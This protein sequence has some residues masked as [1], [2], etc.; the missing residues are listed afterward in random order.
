MDEFISDLTDIRL[1][2]K[3]VNL[4]TALLF[5]LQQTSDKLASWKAPEN[6]AANMAPQVCLNFI[7]T[8]QIINLSVDREYIIGRDHRTQSIRPD[9]DLTPY[10]AYEWGISRLHAK[11]SIENGKVTI[12]DIGSSNGTWHA[13]ERLVPGQPLAVNNG[14]VIF[15]GKLKIQVLIYTQVGNTDSMFQ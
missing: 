2:D 4:P 14:D 11:L 12:T 5:Q 13:G 9:I 15:L 7:D 1:E 3:T 10:S 6:E 8:G